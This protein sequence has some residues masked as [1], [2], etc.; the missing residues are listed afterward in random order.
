M[1]FED[2]KLRVA[3][4]EKELEARSAVLASLQAERLSLQAQVQT[5]A[6]QLEK[7]QAARPTFGVSNLATSFSTLLTNLQST[8]ATPSPSGVVATLRS[9]DL[10]VKGFVAVEGE[11]ANVVVPKP[12]EAIDANMLSSVKMSFVTVPAPA[13][14][15]T[16]QDRSDFV[17]LARSLPVRAVAGIGRTFSQR[18]AEARI[19]T[20]EQ[21]LNRSPDEVARILK[22]SRGRA[23]QVQEL[24][25]KEVL[26]RTNR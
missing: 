14:A 18:L 4:L 26:D 2:L 22:T 8:A 17:S 12:G 15:A 11:N 21:L 19:V 9:I 24:A 3:Q 1:T 23:A 5:L 13:P 6:S 7:L 10:E 20:I 25:R 16:L